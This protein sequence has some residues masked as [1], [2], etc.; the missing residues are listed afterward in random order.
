[1]KKFVFLGVVMMLVAFM[2]L[3][4]KA[5]V[6]LNDTF[7][8]GGR[9]NGADAQDTAWFAT[10]KASTVTIAVG[11]DSVLSGGNAQS[12]TTTSTSTTIF[13]RLAGEFSSQTLTNVG[14]WIS[15]SVDFRLTS[16]GTGGNTSRAFKVGLLNN[17]GSS[18]TADLT[19]SAEPTSS[20]PT[21]LSNDFGYFVGIG[22]GTTGTTALAQ[23]VG[24]GATFLA[25]TDLNYLTP[26]AG[27]S[28]QIRDLLAHSLV[29][30]IT[31]DTATTL[32]IDFNLDGG[33][34]DLTSGGGSTLYTTFNEVGLSTGANA[35]GFVIDNVVVTIPEP[36]T[37]ALLSLGFFA[38]RKRKN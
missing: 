22:S 10:E 33:A 20:T 4:A 32:K 21:P 15:L 12:L 1:M 3:A 19:N 7:T 17:N 31:K 6:V 28:P 25:G 18:L 37:I 27:L 35:T 24:T 29:L 2:P 5:T 11:T 30:T 14:D 8:D 16:L 26:T 9:T 36:A 38:L 13:R 34:I 23:E